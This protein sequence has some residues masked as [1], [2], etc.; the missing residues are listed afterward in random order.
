M[1]SNNNRRIIAVNEVKCLLIPRF[2]LLAH[3][4]T[5]LWSIIPQ[6]LK[7]RIPTTKDAFKRYVM[8]KTW[9]IS[10]RDVAGKFIKRPS[11]NFHSL[12]P[13]SIRLN[14]DYESE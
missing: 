3:N 7:H 13:F 9:E 2:W 6:F 14:Y 10:R 4:E 1:G 12:I 5:N 8:E 11:K